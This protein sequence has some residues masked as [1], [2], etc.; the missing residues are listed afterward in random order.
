MAVFDKRQ[1]NVQSVIAELIRRLNDN[2]K[3]LRLVEQKTISAEAGVANIDQSVLEQFK[4]VKSYMDKLNAKIE[5]LGN[6]ISK[7]EDDSRK[8]S[9]Q[10]ERTSTKTELREVQGF[11]DLINPMKSEFITRAEVKRM[12]EDYKKSAANAA[13]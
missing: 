3:R 7:L 9:K 2:S 12:L 5:D 13:T 8:M 6:R 11:I 4:Q 10:L 1:G